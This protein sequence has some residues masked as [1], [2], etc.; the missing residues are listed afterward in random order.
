MREPFLD[1]AGLSSVVEPSN[2]SKSAQLSFG[3]A[4]ELCTLSHRPTNRLRIT[5]A[6]Q[7][8]M[9]NFRSWVAVCLCFSP[10]H[11]RKIKQ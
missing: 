8:G 11:M 1:A 4:D 6:L 10:P 3:A 5:T 9:Q 2:R 7:G